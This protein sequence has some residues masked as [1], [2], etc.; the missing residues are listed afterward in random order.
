VPHEHMQRLEIHGKAAAAA[1]CDH[2]HTSGK[3]Y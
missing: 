1:D 3:P 2:F